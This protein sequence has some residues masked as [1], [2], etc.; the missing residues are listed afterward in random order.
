MLRHSET[1]A[2]T[3]AS[4]LGHNLKM[5]TH[6]VSKT[7]YKVSDFITWARAGTLILSPSFQRRSV[8][9]VGAKSFLL[10]T[11]VRELP[12]PIIF[13]REQKT[14]LDTLEPKR[15]VVDGQQRI[16]TVLAFLVPKLVKNFDPNR[17]DFTIKKTHNKDLAGKPFTD[18]PPEVKQTIL[19]YQFS[20]HVLPSSVDDR[21]VLQIFAR[22]NAT[23]LKLNAQELRNAAYFGEF[24]TSM[25][26]I[27]AEQLP[28]WRRWRIFTEAQISRMSEVEITS[29]FAQLMIGGIVGKTQKAI[30]KV[31]KELEDE[32]PE[33]LEVERRFR[34]CMEEMDN[35]LGGD[36]ANTAFTNRAAFHG[37]F[38]AV[39]AAAFEIGSSLKREKAG[40]LPADFKAR[41]LKTSDT[42]R[43]AKAPDKVLDALARRTTH[44][45]SRKTVIDYLKAQLFHA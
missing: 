38:A 9:P 5:Q 15:E 37:L 36:L 23:G 7:H 6:Q 42:I 39:Y 44:K 27:S 26:A 21:E 20:V 2:R 45:D 41:V 24:K 12:I 11:I 43:E 17:D 28:R 16:R 32:W 1:E 4:H 29:E 19:D 35:A 13:L 40:P 34:H 3:K 31:Y 33:R 22:M 8:W 18:L 30:D 14:D 10:D 25:Y